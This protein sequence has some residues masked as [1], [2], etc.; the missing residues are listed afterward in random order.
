MIGGVVLAAGAGRRFGGPKQLHPV[1]GVPMLERVVT[2]VADAGLDDLVV[3]L[4][5]RADE[6]EAQ[7]NLRTARVVRAEQWDSGQA[8]S[9]RAGLDALQADIT[10]ALVVLGD[11]PQL[12]PAAVQRVRS[13]A[14]AA[15]GQ[16]LAADYGNG[17]SHPV[18]LPRAV[19][20]QLPEAGEAAA[21]R[22]LP[23]IRS[24]LEQHPAT[25]SGKTA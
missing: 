7:V 17:R 4:G 23:E 2:I 14:E 3:V 18:L 20:A 6:V 8:A 15:P 11:G 9:L 16:V 19:W 1:N 25:L 10:A 24:W 22:A 5:A 12:D 13:A 21:E